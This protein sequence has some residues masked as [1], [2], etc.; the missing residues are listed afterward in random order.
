MERYYNQN[1]APGIH[2]NAI[3]GALLYCAD[4]F[5]E[6]KDEIWKT[7][8]LA[9]LDYRHRKGHAADSA[10]MNLVFEAKKCSQLCRLIDSHEGTPR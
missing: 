3:N 1:G 10:T 2:T 6:T 9:Y 8:Y 7:R 4:K 5:T